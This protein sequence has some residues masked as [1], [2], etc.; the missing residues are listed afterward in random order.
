MTLM[1]LDQHD[2]R[3][4]QKC[5]PLS[6]PQ[7]RT[8]EQQLEIEALLNYVRGVVDKDAPRARRE[9]N[10]PSTVGLSANQA[11]IM[12]QICVVDLSIG[13]KGYTDLY[14]LV[15]PKISWKSKAKVT[16]TEGCVNF[17]TTWGLTKRSTSVK[18]SAW[19]RSGNEL[20]LRLSGWPAS[21]LQHEIDHL[22]G[23]LFIDRMPDPAHAHHVDPEEYAVYRKLKPGQWQSFV[24]MSREAV[25]PEGGLL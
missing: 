7:L 21:L 18:V 23:L 24:D 4:R 22:E 13:R 12:K 25:L 3:L 9:H 6:R 1:P 8:R 17:P 10:R 15:N 16:R 2:P 14:V 20:V 19:D 5:A 11:G